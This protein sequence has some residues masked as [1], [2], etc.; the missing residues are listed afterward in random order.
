M[1]DT[2]ES[3]TPQGAAKSATESV[4]RAASDVGSEV[5]STAEELRDETVHHAREVAEDG[6]NSLADRLERLAG[7]I[8]SA[9]SSL[10][11]SDPWMSRVADSTAK[12]VRDASDHFHGES[13]SELAGEASD[14]ARRHP[15]VFLGGA[16]AIGVALARL[17]RA[18]EPNDAPHQAEDFHS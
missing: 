11:E 15:A 9:A 13:L 2:Q 8:G 1:S 5:R 12:S 6:K 14:L 17:T 3:N 10:K 18:H 16:V 4:R 7:A